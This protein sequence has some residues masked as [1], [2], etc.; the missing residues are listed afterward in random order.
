MNVHQTCIWVDSA[1]RTLPTTASTSTLGS[2]EIRRLRLPW[3]RRRRRRFRRRRASCRRGWS[4]CVRCTWSACFTSARAHPAPGSSWTSPTTW[5]SAALVSA[6]TA[7]NAPIISAPKS[8]WV[9][10]TDMGVN[11]EGYGERVPQ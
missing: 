9:R 2:T 8:P 6:V 5:P 1:C 10:D 4:G 11:L 3:K 7:T